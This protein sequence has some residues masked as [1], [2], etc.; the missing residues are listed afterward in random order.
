MITIR[1]SDEFVLRSPG[2]FGCCW[3]GDGIYLETL[4]DDSAPT[5]ASSPPGRDAGPIH[6]VQKAR[7]KCSSTC[8]HRKS[9]FRHCVPLVK[10]FVFGRREAGSCGVR[11]VRVHLMCTR[12]AA[13]FQR[14]RAR[15]CSPAYPSPIFSFIQLNK[16]IGSARPGQPIFHHHGDYCQAWLTTVSKHGRPSLTTVMT[17]AVHGDQ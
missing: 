17:V 9:I 4:A 8:L 6:A 12:E 11:P 13:H 14:N 10:Y 16:E 2:G 15:A 3:F 7:R 1:S 5:T